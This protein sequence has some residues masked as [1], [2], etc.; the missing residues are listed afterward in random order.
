MKTIR[1]KPKCLTFKASPFV[2]AWV[3]FM[4]LMK[5]LHSKRA[6]EIA[7]REAEKIDKEMTK[8]G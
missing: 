4:N 5:G 7:K 2:M 6:M 1:F 3:E 8:N